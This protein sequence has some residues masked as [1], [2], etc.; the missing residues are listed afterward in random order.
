MEKRRKALLAAIG[1]R[2][3][4]FRE[5]RGWTQTELAERLGLADYRLVSQFE[6]GRRDLRVSTVARLAEALGAPPQE[7]FPA[8]AGGASAFD[9]DFAYLLREV[10]RYGARDRD[11]VR[12]VLAA[13][14]GE[15]E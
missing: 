13:Y 12:R 5:L 10:S 1:K 11:R 3:R 15:R 9:E 14:I 7:L 2:I 4:R 6:N 8:P